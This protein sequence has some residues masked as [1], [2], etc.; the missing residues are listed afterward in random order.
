M[1]LQSSDEYNELP[2]VNPS[3][4]WYV[5]DD[6]AYDASIGDIDDIFAFMNDEVNEMNMVFPVSSPIYDT[7]T[8]EDA[9]ISESFQIDSLE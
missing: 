9:L 4:V 1:C 7:S 5:S 8:D 2:Y 6:D 3:P